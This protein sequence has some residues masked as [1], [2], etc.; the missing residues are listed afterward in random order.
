MNHIAIF[1]IGLAYILYLTM[2]AGILGLVYGG[3]IYCVLSFP[4]FTLVTVVFLAAYLVG[5]HL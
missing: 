1:F 2:V 5:R 4:V 3:L